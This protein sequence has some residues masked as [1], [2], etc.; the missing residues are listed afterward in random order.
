VVIAALQALVILVPGWI[1][2]GSFFQFMAMLW[3]PIV[4]AVALLVWWVL[5]SRLRTADRWLGLLAFA[6]T[7]ALAWLVC[8]P[9][10]GVFGLAIYAL[11]TVTTAW[12]LWLLMTPALSWPIRR[13][14][15]AVV[16]LL[17]WGYFTLLRL[18]GVDGSMSASLPFRWSQ[19]AEEKFLAEIAAGKHKSDPVSGATKAQT[20]TL[21]SG[22]WPGFRGP[23]RDGHLTGVR[24]ATD[25]QRH[26]PQQVWRHRIGPGWSSFAVVGTRLFTQEQR[27]EDELVI[28]YDA[29][30]GAEQWSHR[31][32]D[33]FT[34]IVSG[35]GPRATPTFHEG[36][37][38]AL[39]A[40]GQLNC[41]DA[42]TGQVIWSCNI[43]TDSGAKVPNWGFAASPLVAHGIVTVFAGGPDGK[44]MLG[45]DASSGKPAWAAGEGQLSYCS[46]QLAQLDGIEQVLITTEAGLTG[47]HPTRGD[48]LWRHGWPVEGIARIVQPTLLGDSE[49]LIGTGMGVGTRRV[50]ISRSG[51]GWTEKELWTS[52][53]I[54]PYFNDLV[55][56]HGHLYGFDGN[57][58]TCVSLDDGKGKWRARGYG[59]GQILLLADQDLLLVLSEKGEV[60]L[61][62][63]DPGGHTEL[64]RF[65]A[66][67]GKTWNHPVVAHGKLYVRN[68]EE[69][70]CYRL[71]EIPS[72]SNAGQ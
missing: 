65:K 67:E 33:R 36:Q 13:M 54:K 31:D 61:V 15:L 50:R 52:R 41:L 20:L 10:F 62:K 57:F 40:K 39:G 58:L 68:G 29:E 59:N 9:T 37:I 6:A 69:A 44:S 4:G 2:P 34:E 23:N 18:E 19:T 51:D 27:G 53:A 42:A 24:I 1:M 45:Y 56:H 46:P 32:R 17:G 64:A 47:F 72:S 5:A 55:V 30:S 70:A 14:G 22:D 38:Y 60:A 26:L 35:A 43:A 11:P 16:F 48:V 21:Q 8:H 12:V 25:W 49:V 71:E 7:G 66:I 28:C 63:A 3:G